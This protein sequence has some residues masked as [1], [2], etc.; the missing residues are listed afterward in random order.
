MAVLR[1]RLQSTWTRLLQRLRTVHCCALSWCAVEAQGSTRCAR[2]QRLETLQ[3]MQA[4]WWQLHASQLATEACLWPLMAG[5]APRV[6]GSVPGWVA[7][8]TYM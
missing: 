4:G 2:C 5:P 8:Y 7:P 1:R 3:P 6:R